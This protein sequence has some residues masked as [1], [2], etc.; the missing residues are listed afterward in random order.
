MKCYF[1]MLRQSDRFGP[2]WWQK[3][4]AGE[5]EIRSGSIISYLEGR[6][7]LTPSSP[8]LPAVIQEPTACPLRHMVKWRSVLNARMHQDLNRP[9]ASFKWCFFKI[10]PDRTH[11]YCQQSYYSRGSYTVMKSVCISLQ[12]VALFKMTILIQCW[13]SRHRGVAER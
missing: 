2:S 7:G 6:A 9:L 8:P 5:R 13:R 11:P 3:L 1:Y 4:R 12:S 10:K